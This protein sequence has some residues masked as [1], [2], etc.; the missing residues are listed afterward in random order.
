VDLTTN[1][2]PFN[3]G[4]GF[5]PLGL[6]KPRGVLAL[7]LGS[8]GLAVPIGIYF[9]M[10]RGLSIMPL[11]LIGALL[12]LSYTTFLTRL[13]G[14]IAEAA[15]GLGLGT[16][17]VIG[18]YYIITGEITAEALFA[19]VPSGILVANLLLL[20]EIPDAEADVAGKRKT[21]PII[22]GKKKAAVVYSAL[23]IA[24]YVWIILGVLA[25]SMPAWTL[26]AC[27]T[28]PFAFKAITGSFAHEDAGKFVAAQGANVMVVLLTQ[29]FLGIG[30]ILSYAL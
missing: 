5:L 7:G 2:T 20:N 30:F 13:G 11:F 23:T 19:S 17:P 26:L 6:L 18:I 1:R 14:G 25:G 29:L 22:L 9:V 27:V 8:F 12:V 10:Q 21:L 15:A 3:G 4:S 28:L 24:T 16:L